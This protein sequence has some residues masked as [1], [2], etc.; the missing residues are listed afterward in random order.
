MLPPNHYVNSLLFSCKESA[1]ELELSKRR[2]VDTGHY[3]RGILY[4][5]TTTTTITTTTTLQCIPS[6]QSVP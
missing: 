1:T 6:I 2:G 3:F 4:Q 5:Q